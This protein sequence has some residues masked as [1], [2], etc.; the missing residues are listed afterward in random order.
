MRGI[1]FKEILNFDSKALK[2]RAHVRLGRLSGHHSSPSLAA[3]PPPRV[4][5]LEDVSSPA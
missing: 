5:P 3:H 2:P 4:T 1:G